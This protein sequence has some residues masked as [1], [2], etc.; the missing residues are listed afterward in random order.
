MSNWLTK[1]Q[2]KAIHICLF[3]VFLLLLLYLFNPCFRTLLASLEID[4]NFIIGFF[5]VIA[6]LLGLIQSS[7]DK[8]Y[9]YNLKLV[10]SIEDKG[11]RII[12]KLLG[13]RQKS[14]TMLS[15]L[16]HVKKSIDD[17]II[18]HDP[19]NTLDKSDIESDME[20]VTAFINTYFP[21]QAENWNELLT[22]LSAIGTHN[23]NVLLNYN[24]NMELVSKFVPFKNTALNNID[25]S[26]SDAEAINQRIDAMTLKIRDGIVE[27]INKTK[28]QI[29]NSFDFKL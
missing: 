23:V 28:T 19:N 6:V 17:K 20:L 1:L 29:V 8:R 11:L 21:E 26:I 25:F 24:G 15:T 27:K 18:Y 7:R 9:A 2:S 3:F 4:P 10:E 22:D 14:A 5:T 13:I 12:G 16:K